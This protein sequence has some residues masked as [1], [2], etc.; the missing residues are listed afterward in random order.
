PELLRQAAGR[1]AKTAL[2]LRMARAAFAVPPGERTEELVKAAV[3]GFVL[4][5]Y[6]FD[7]YRTTNRDERGSR[8]LGL[9][10]LLGGGDGE[11]RGALHSAVELAKQVAH[12]TNWA[13]DLVNEPAGV[14]TPKRLALEA[15]RIA[16]E[17]RL[18]VSVGGR[19]EIQKLRMGLFLG[20]AQGSAEKPRLIHLVY[21]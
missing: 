12:A 19:K 6:R 3:E 14:L 2:K 18:A 13:R 21:T 9:V 5:A 7:R 1:A 20:V 15:K 17:G 16:R 10:H 4:G 8:P 11:A